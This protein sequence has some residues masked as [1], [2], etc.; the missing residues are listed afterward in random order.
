MRTVVAATILALL[1]AACAQPG[2]EGE[3]QT[4]SLGYGWS[5]GETFTY[6][7][8][9]AMSMSTEVE[10]LPDADLS[11]P[12]DMDLSA[13]LLTSYSFADGA[14]PGT[15]RVTMHYDDITE[16]SVTVRNGDEELSMDEGDL[17]D[18]QDE[19]FGG[20]GVEFIVDESGQILSLSV[21]GS[22]IP[23]PSFA[24]Q[25]LGAASSAMPFLGP[26]LPDREIAV[27]DVW[28][29]SWATEAFPGQ[30][31]S[32]SADSSLAAI[33][34]IDGVELYVIETTTTSSAVELDLA[35]L[36]G[37]LAEG[38]GGSE[39]DVPS[40]ISFAMTL[41]QA[42]GVAT[43]WFDPARGITVRQTFTSGTDMA[44]TFSG[45]GEAG[46]MTM[47]IVTSGTLELLD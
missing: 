10:G 6:E 17:A 32:I 2:T 33:E 22:D 34:T 27:G 47:H 8:D 37:G 25:G 41:E 11:E 38:F 9:F 36:L 1:A 19:V 30:E 24:G 43:V 45:E 46:S 5:A 44:I 12:I 15:Y 21:G 35:D 4:V 40:D 42:P 20:E 14:E 18:V 31:L 26:E 13:T 28:S 29:T 16:V 23:L 3:S 7:N 39:A